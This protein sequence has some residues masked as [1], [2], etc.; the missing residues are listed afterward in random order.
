MV[1]SKNSRKNKRNTRKKKKC[2]FCNNSHSKKFDCNLSKNLIIGGASVHLAY[3]YVILNNS[4]F[5]NHPN[6][7][8]YIIKHIEK[9]ISYMK[10]DDNANRTYIAYLDWIIKQTPDISKV[11]ISMKYN[12]INLIYNNGVFDPNTNAFNQCDFLNDEQFL[13]NILGHAFII[14]NRDSN[15]LQIENICLHKRGLENGEYA[16]VLVTNI[17]FACSTT[18]VNPEGY[19]LRIIQDVKNPHFSD[20]IKNYTLFGFGDISLT[21]DLVTGG[22][23][24]K[25]QN[26][27]KFI[28]FKKSNLSFPDSEI[29]KSFENQALNLYNLYKDDIYPDDISIVFEKTAFNFLR[30]FSYMGKIYG[31]TSMNGNDI[32]EYGGSFNIVKKNNKNQYV[33][34]IANFL[35]GD[36]ETTNIPNGPYTF[37]SHP[38]SLYIKYNVLIGTPSAPD[39]RSTIIR[40][41]EFYVKGENPLLGTFHFVI[42]VEGI[43]V[44]LCNFEKVFP[45]I[46]EKIKTVESYYNMINKMDID[47]ITEKLEYNFNERAFN[48]KTGNSIWNQS[49]FDNLDEK[50]TDV[51]IENYKKWFDETAQSIPIF[52][53]LATVNDLLTIQYYSWK[54]L[55]EGNPIEFEN[56]ISEI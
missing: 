6:F 7:K 3:T 52:D 1:L 30:L 10:S 45:K 39:I 20:I 55:G 34:S 32:I 44:V 48:D 40:C 41:K 49:V 15:E 38:I 13:E 4:V 46:V 53:G 33:L 28:E 11:I 35:Y 43:Y 16:S 8:D 47:T 27:I 23:G 51:Y 31:I 17:V 26:F 14:A 36:F 12:F 22:M 42:T 25:S 21:K 19:K 9:S 29:T 50:T 24:I 56:N 54:S 5:T 18:F 37:H 2:S